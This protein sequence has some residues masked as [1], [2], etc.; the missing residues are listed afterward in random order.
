MNLK[1]KNYAQQRIKRPCP[2]KAGH[3]VYARP[4]AI[5]KNQK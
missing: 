3:G 4:L 1:N 5:M 2:A